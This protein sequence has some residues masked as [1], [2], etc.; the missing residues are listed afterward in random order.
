[1][2]FKSLLA[3]TL[4]T[5]LSG[6][7]SA[8]EPFSVPFRDGL[9]NV[10]ESAWQLE[11][12]IDAMQTVQIA[13]NPGCYQEVGTLYYFAGHHPSESQVLI[14]SLGFAAAHY[15]AAKLIERYGNNTVQYIFQSFTLVTK[16]QNIINNAN[17]GL[18][19]NHSRSCH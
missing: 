3:V 14:V 5:A 10:S 9:T 12:V 8:R 1:M 19:L 13:K 7:V 6:T 17:I 18:G 4:V 16:S 2:R 15:G 11:N